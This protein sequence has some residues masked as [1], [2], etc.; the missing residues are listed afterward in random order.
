[1]SVLMGLQTPTTRTLI[2]VLCISAGVALASYGEVQFALSGFICQ[3]LGIAFEA[4]RLVAIEKLLHGLKM[5]PLVS[6]YYFAPVS[7]I[8]RVIGRYILK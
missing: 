8:G 6:L 7:C 1:M 3:A 2:I 4:C 5:D